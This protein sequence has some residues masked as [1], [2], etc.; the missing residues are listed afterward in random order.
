[1]TGAGKGSKIMIMIT[2][3]THGDLT[4]F[5]NPLLKKLKKNDALIIT[6]DFGC[7]WN[8]DD[9][10]KKVLKALGK[11]KYNVLFVEGVH[12]NYSL[13][14]QYPIEEWCGGK[15]HRI[16]PNLIHLMRGQYYTIEGKTFLTMGGALSSDRLLRT[17]NVDWW[18]RLF[19]RKWLRLALPRSHF[20]LFPHRGHLC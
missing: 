1:M 16:R 3:D 7:I 6:G 8:G 18:Y 2:G 11:K 9:R 13:L 12:E 10:E 5:K 14:A 15:I 4:R 19:E 17:E 20:W